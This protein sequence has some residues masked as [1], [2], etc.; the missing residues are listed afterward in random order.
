[1]VPVVAPVGTVVKIWLVVA[2]FTM[3]FVPLKVTVF[4]PAVLLK[5]VPLIVTAVPTG[6]LFGVKSM[7]EVWPAGFLEIETRFPTGSYR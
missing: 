2:E 1:M 4:C 5:A 7:I 6:P 3:A